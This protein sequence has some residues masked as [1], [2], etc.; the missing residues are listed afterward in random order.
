MVGYERLLGLAT[1][2]GVEASI[3]LFVTKLA[4][5][6]PDPPGTQTSRVVRV[7]CVYRMLISMADDIVGASL[8]P[9]PVAVGTLVW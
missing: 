9:E 3:E 6:E 5:D 4:R 8:I 7:V 1:V 2:V